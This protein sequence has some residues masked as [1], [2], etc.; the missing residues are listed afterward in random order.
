MEESQNLI[1]GDQMVDTQN[2]YVNYLCGQCGKDVELKPKEITIR[3]KE[4]GFRIL[5]KKQT[6]QV[7]Q[8]LAR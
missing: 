8:F 4:C 6:K 5:F 7:M 2:T 3:C 1:E